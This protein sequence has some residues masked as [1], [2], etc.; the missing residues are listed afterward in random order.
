MPDRKIY[1][2]FSK[3]RIL[4]IVRDIGDF[5]ARYKA[6]IREAMAAIPLAE[7]Q[8]EIDRTYQQ[9]ADAAHE[10]P[11][12][13]FGNDAFD[14]NPSLSQG[15]RGSALRQ[16]GRP[17]EERSLTSGQPGLRLASMKTPC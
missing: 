9:I 15:L 12:K 7:L 13:G 11:I 17:S 14:W 2:R 6:K 8:A 4:T 16:R 1:A 3:S 10:D 5:R